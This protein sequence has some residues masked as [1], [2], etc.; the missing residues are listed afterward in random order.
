MRTRVEGL[1]KPGGETKVTFL[2]GLI[3]GTN[4]SA[5]ARG[6]PI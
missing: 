3:R 4:T 5:Q 2:Y 1:T 6:S